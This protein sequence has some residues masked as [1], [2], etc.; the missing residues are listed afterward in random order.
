[1]LSA[2]ALTNTGALFPSFL[3]LCALF[4]R[5]NPQLITHYPLGAILRQHK[6]GALRQTYRINETVHRRVEMRIV[7]RE[8]RRPRRWA[9]ERL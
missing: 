7:G 8:A 6:I 4:S 3:A 5:S 1:M 9:G 2:A